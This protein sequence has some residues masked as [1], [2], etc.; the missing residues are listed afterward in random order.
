MQ[1][2]EMTIKEGET[3][4]TSTG[5]WIPVEAAMPKSGKIVLA[6]YKNS[7]GNGRVVRAMWA[8]KF[9]LE[10]DEEYAEY[11]EAQDAYFAAEGWYECV[12]NWDDYSSFSIYQGKVTHWMPMP[13]G[14]E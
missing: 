10:S 14:P 2:N 8:E 6:F 9:T 11:C 3:V 1:Y 5:S 4:F 12:E 13:K 7:L